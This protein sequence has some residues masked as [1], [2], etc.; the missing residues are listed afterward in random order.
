MAPQALAKSK[1]VSQFLFFNQ[2]LNKP[3]IKP[4]PAPKTLNTSI[5][6]FLPVIPFSK[7]DLIV[8]SKI[9]APYG[10]LLQTK[11]ASVKDLTFFKAFI[12]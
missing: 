12:V 8:F 11:T 2:P 9:L 4:S 6:K 3:A 1:H 5:L 7:F 10:P